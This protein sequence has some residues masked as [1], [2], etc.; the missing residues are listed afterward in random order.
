VRILP[1]YTLKPLF[2]VVL[3][4]LKS[5]SPQLVS[6]GQILLSYLLGRADFK[7]K[8]VA[9]VTKAVRKLGK[10]SGWASE[11][12]LMLA[13]L[14]VRTQ[15]ANVER[16]KGLGLLVSFEPAVNVLVNEAKGSRDEDATAVRDLAD[17]LVYTLLSLSGPDN[18]N[19]TNDDDGNVLL[20]LN[21]VKA[22]TMVHSL[23][24]GVSP[25]SEHTVVF[26]TDMAQKLARACA[27]DIAPIETMTEGLKQLTKILSVVERSYPKEFQKVCAAVTAA[28]AGSAADIFFLG[29]A[30]SRSGDLQINPPEAVV[31]AKRALMDNPLVRFLLERPLRQ[32]PKL[33]NK[34]LVKLMQACCAY[35]DAW[36]RICIEQC[37][38]STGSTCFWAFGSGSISLRYGSGYFSSKQK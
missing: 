10:K 11:E 35:G 31:R 7:A 21:E 13:V 27:A 30:N 29:G 5:A 19:E 25:L 12:T 23:L 20:G 18:D 36:I 32:L 15:A 17:N 16:G 14:L 24:K 9:K 37:S 8:T 34:K 6:S 4:L 38:G 3:A 22:F 1:Y 2:Q 33:A 26:A 28:A